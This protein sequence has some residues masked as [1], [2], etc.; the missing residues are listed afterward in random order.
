MLTVTATAFAR[1][2]LRT[3]SESVNPVNVI[4]IVASVVMS[5]PLVV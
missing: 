4:V 1:V 5:S 3:A 2:C